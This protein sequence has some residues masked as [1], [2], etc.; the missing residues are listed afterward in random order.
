MFCLCLLGDSKEEVLMN[1]LQ[2]IVKKVASLPTDTLASPSGSEGSPCSPW[3]LKEIN[4]YVQAFSRPRV[5][6]NV[7]AFCTVLGF[8]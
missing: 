8:L 6:G 7:Q 4:G 2:E 1:A 3:I 5:N